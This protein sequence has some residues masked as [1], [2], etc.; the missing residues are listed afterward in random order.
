MW[1]IR[2]YQMARTLV[3]NGHHTLPES[4]NASIVAG[5]AH[6][7]SMLRAFIIKRMDMVVND[8]PFAHIQVTVDDVSSFVAGRNL[9][10]TAARA[11]RVFDA[12]ADHLQHGLKGNVSMDKTVVL[13]SS[14]RMHEA[15]KERSSCKFRGADAAANLGVD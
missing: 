4:F 11:A 2:C 7:T 3:V 5:C 15:V 13:S 9:K 12:I 14:G 6:A 8:A 1:C 10:G